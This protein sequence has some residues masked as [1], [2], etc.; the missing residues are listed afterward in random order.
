MFIHEIAAP[1]VTSDVDELES[2]P[3]D[4]MADNDDVMDGSIGDVEVGSDVLEEGLLLLL[5]TAVDVIGVTFEASTEEATGKVLVEDEIVPG[6]VPVVVVVTDADVLVVAIEGGWF[7]FVGAKTCAVPNPNN[8]PQY[9]LSSISSS[10]YISFI[11]K[12]V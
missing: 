8:S 1:G 2:V 6:V 11:R 3:E 5:L 12:K 4:N 7:A 10:K 9:L